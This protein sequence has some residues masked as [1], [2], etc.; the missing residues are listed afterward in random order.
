MTNPLKALREHAREIRDG[1]I[2]LWWVF[3]IVLPL[4]GFGLWLAV[5]HANANQARALHRS[6][7]QFQKA[8]IVTDSKFHQAL[9]IQTALFAYSTNKSVCTLRPF[10]TA[11]R[12]ARLA[13]VKTATDG[14]DRKLNQDAANTYK[15]L[16]D[17]QV[18]V[19]A[20][21]NCKTLPKKP[22]SPVVPIKPR[23]ATP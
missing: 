22:P 23:K 12:I 8:L 1:V 4:T 11:A 15:R 20:D 19:P 9:S 2:H 14:K 3:V 7:L 13:A 21:F 17:G 10:L 6:N 5:D 18:T 16:I